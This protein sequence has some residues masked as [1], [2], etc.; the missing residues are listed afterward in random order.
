MFEIIEI[1]SNLKIIPLIKYIFN[2][3][4]FSTIKNIRKKFN[5]YMRIGKKIEMSEM[6]TTNM[7]RALKA[8]RRKA[9]L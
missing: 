7:S 2:I 5:I 1:F 3:N 4:I 9:S 8:L 6:M